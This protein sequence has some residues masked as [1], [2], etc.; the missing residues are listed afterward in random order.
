MAINIG[1][2]RAGIV[3]VVA[4]L[5]TVALGAAVVAV[6][7]SGPVLEFDDQ[8]SDGYS[9]VLSE[10][11]LEH[12]G[13][14][15]VRNDA[16]DVLWTNRGYIDLPYLEPGETYSGRVSFER[17]L[18]HDQTLTAVLINDTNRNRVYDE[19][20]DTVVRTQRAWITL[21]VRSDF[22]E[23]AE[24]WAFVRS[25]DQSVNDY[26]REPQAPEHRASDGS[27]GGYIAASDDLNGPYWDGQ[28]N[29]LREWVAP[30]AYLG[31]RENFYGGTFS[32]MARGTVDWE[33]CTAGTR[34]E[35]RSTLEYRVTFYSDDRALIYEFK[36]PD[37]AD[38]GFNAE[39]RSAAPGVEWTQYMV[40]LAAPAN[41]TERQHGTDD[42]RWSYYVPAENAYY[43]DQLTE[44]TF[45]DVFSEIDRIEIRAESVDSLRGTDCEAAAA[46]DEGHLDSVVLSGSPPAEPVGATPSTPAA[47][48]PP[49]TPTTA[50][51]PA[52]EAPETTVGSEPDPTVTVAD[53]P[54]FTATLAVVALLVTTLWA[55]R[56][57]RGRQR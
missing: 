43:V 22:D 38:A 1:F 32:F 44:R 30:A 6:A 17:A 52:P 16:G 27:P 46:V 50:E 55:V 10:I 36:N 12:G 48:T 42:G 39:W 31:D 25:T 40:P 28:G 54:G 15:D 29:G 23:G 4:W 53:T 56:R 2:R 21:Q 34:Y 9:V 35:D 26:L 51:S 14:V 19:G 20:V 8:T 13:W 37:Y 33:R 57:G 5:V 41:V 18:D 47:V 3:L 24:G 11:A 7:Q 49:P 45:R